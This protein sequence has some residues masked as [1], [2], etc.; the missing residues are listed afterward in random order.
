MSD[1][2]PT[3]QATRRGLGVWRRQV[4][5]SLVFAALLAL[6]VLSFY[7]QGRRREWALRATQAQHRLDIA[8][9]TF[10]QELQ[11]I[12]ADALFLAD[13]TGGRH[14]ASPSLV[15]DGG[16]DNEFRER[17]TAEYADF[18]RR[19]AIYDQIRLI[20]LSGQEVIRVNLQ[21]GK[22]VAVPPE[23][24][25]DKSDRYYFQAARS[26]GAG[27]VFVSELDLN[28]EHGKIENPLK[29]VIRFTTPVVDAQHN[30]RGYL[31]LNYLGSHLLAKLQNQGVPGATLLLRY[32]SHYVLGLR[33]EQCW[34]WLLG[35]AITFAN[36]FPR[37][38][39]RIDNMSEGVLTSLGLFAARPIS[40]S[41]PEGVSHQHDRRGTMFAVSYLPYREVFA[42]SRDLLQRL[43]LLA[44]SVLVPWLIFARYWAHA[45][46]ARETQARQIASSEERL[47]ELSARL[48]RLQEEERKAISREI[49]D[50]LGQQVTAISLDLKL[51]Q[52]NISSE[53]GIEQ[54]QQAIDRNQHLL[55]SL[56][57]FARRVRPAV[58]DDLGLLDALRSQLAEFQQRTEVEVDADLLPH[59]DGIPDHIADSVYRLVQESLTNVAKHAGATRVWLSMDVSHDSDPSML[60]LRVRDDGR[61]GADEGAGNRLGLVGMRERV[62]LL[63][64]RIE[65]AS[66]ATQG[67]QVIIDIPLVAPAPENGRVCRDSPTRS[68]RN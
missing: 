21:Q 47:R 7:W 31:A 46:L 62:D 20:D 1:D 25:Q 2:P 16:P 11:R 18:V 23:A 22:G 39:A 66:S 33:D 54:L 48:L 8:Y 50:E 4:A 55:D 51:V 53:K 41:R 15:T 3:E 29:P 36:E 63:G 59:G 32:D 24:L 64:G 35:H 17:L 68:T 38:W 27:E 58:L 42:T 57:A 13:Q 26:L 67:T 40:L 43:L 6:L 45:T 28:Q 37:E 56:H 19:K 65:V 5:V 61:G 14:L 60:H 9:E 12:M 44:A 30:V 49:H 10:S 52:R 34:G